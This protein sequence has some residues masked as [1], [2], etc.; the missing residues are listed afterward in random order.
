MAEGGSGPPAILDSSL[1]TSED[2]GPSV[3]LSSNAS[4]ILL[5]PDNT[6][7]G[8]PQDQ[9]RMINNINSLLSEVLS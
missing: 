8:I 6:F 5:S 2:V 1:N 3:S 7:G 4:S 9:L